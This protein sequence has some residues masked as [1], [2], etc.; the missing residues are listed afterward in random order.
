MAKFVANLF[1]GSIKTYLNE[2]Q[3]ELDIEKINPEYFKELFD[4]TVISKSISSSVAK[5]IIVES[6]LKDKRPI[7]IATMNGLMQISDTSQLEEICK[8]VI[9]DNPKAV[10]DYKKN[11]A[12]IG[13][14]VGQVM[15]VSH[16]SANPSL[17]REILE[18]LLK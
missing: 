1:L 14:L 11:P 6:Y 9:I 15:K 12:T 3:E 13:F 4:E 16:G 17:V 18:K 2:N 7:E 10:E 5:Q 8:Q